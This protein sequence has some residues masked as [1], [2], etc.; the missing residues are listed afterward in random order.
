MPSTAD[1][2]AAPAIGRPHERDRRLHR[3]HQLD[4]P[5]RGPQGLRQAARRV[6]TAIDKAEAGA[7]KL[8]ADRSTHEAS[9]AAAKTELEARG[10][11]L[12]KR[13]TAVRIAEHRLTE[14]ERAIEAAKPPRSTPTE[15]SQR[16]TLG[17]DTTKWR[18][19]RSGDQAADVGGGP[20]PRRITRAYRVSIG[21]SA[22]GSAD[23]RKSSSGL[24]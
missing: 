13:E 9:V 8:A 12:L 18:S 16:E 24:R 15:T 11:A 7:A 23:P 2:T 14:R 1:V 22:Q 19:G 21:R 10:A 17:E 4:R 6:R 20:R 3:G 5:R